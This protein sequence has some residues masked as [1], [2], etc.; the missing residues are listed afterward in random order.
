MTDHDHKLQVLANKAQKPAG[1]VGKMQE[2]DRGKEEVA[3]AGKIPNE[4]FEKQVAT[5]VEV[6]AMLSFVPAGRSKS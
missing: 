6:E 2:E 4:L 5:A 1:V 3:S